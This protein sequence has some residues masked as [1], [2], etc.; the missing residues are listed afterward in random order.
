MPAV[1]SYNA[2]AATAAKIG[3]ER[4]I[5]H[6]LFL[7]CGVKADQTQLLR[8]GRLE[9][10]DIIPDCP[11]CNPSTDVNRVRQVLTEIIKTSRDRICLSDKFRYTLHVNKSFPNGA[12]SRQKEG[13]ISF[14]RGT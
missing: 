11:G 6:L 4:D 8:H 1:I 10:A 13:C 14:W 2:E 12:E 5:G 3:V 9:F 7:C